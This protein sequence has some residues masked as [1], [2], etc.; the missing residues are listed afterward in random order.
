M[1]YVHK[2]TTSS[3]SAATAAA[4]YTRSQQLMV[5]IWSFQR[6]FVEMLGC[7]KTHCVHVCCQKVVKILSKK[8]IKYLL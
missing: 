8:Q 5:L 6:L 4:I 2:T 3:S 7:I 1:H